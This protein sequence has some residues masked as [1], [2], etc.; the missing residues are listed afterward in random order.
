MKLVALIESPRVVRAI[1]EHLGLPSEPLEPLRS[2]AP[3]THDDMA[4]ALGWWN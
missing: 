1:L 2:R 3:P 4:A